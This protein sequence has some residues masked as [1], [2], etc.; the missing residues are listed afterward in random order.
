MEQKEHNNEHNENKILPRGRLVRS[1]R[2][3]GAVGGTLGAILAL[4]LAFKPEIG[5]LLDNSYEIKA[6]QDKYATVENLLKEMQKQNVQ[7][8]SLF[9]DCQQRLINCGGKK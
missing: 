1:A 4:I 8:L 2:I 5:K 3:N 7:Y 6:L 9:S